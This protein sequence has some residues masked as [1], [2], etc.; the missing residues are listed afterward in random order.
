MVPTSDQFVNNEPIPLDE[1]GKAHISDGSAC[2]YVCRTMSDD[3]VEVILDLKCAF[4]KPFAVVREQL[5]NIDIGC[6]HVHHLKP[7]G[8]DEGLACTEITKAGHL[9][10]Y[11]SGMCSSKLRILCATSV[12]YPAL[13]TLL[14]AVYML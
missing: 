4:E 13:R 5:Q 8:M 12:H 11:A 1:Q 7:R 3:D 6:P 2:T 14:H 10:P 9:L